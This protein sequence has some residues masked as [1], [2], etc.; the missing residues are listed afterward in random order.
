MRTVVQET[1]GT[2]TAGGIV[3]D[4]SHHRT[5]FIEEELVADA[6]LASRLHEHVPEAHLLV[7]FA[8]QK[9][10]N[11]GIRLL[12]CAIQASREHL[13][14]VEEEGISL[15]EIIQH[16]SEIKMFSL[17]GITL[18]IL[19]EHFYGL[20]PAVKHHQLAL[21]SP[22]NPESS[23]RAVIVRNI[24]NDT[25]RIERYLLLGQMELEL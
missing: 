25:M 16:V 20:R 10:L 1:E 23:R 7:Q 19:L 14:I 18:R 9:D 12:L 21:I 13:R 15:I 3:D 4:L 22:R 5:G 8:E 17:N 24:M 11:L 2:A 6:D